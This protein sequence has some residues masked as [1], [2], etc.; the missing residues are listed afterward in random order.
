[1]YQEY[2]QFQEKPFSLTPDPKFLYP[3]VKHQE[4]LDH[5]LY[6]IRQRE[7]F[8]LM[9]G[10]VGTG[11][12]T[13]CRSLLEKLDADVKTALVL[14]PLGSEM[15]LLRTCLADLGV[16]RVRANRLTPALAGAVEQ[17]P[18][19]ETTP[20]FDEED[21]EGWTGHASKK[22]L[23]DALNEYLLEQHRAGGTVVLI[24]DEAQNLSLPVLEQL[25][26]LSNL[27]TEK[28]KLL[29]I[30]FAGQLE[31]ADK[32]NLPELK[33]L[34]ERIS[35]RCRIAPLS[36]EETQQY[37]MHRVLVAGAGS[38][39]AFAPSGLNAIHDYSKGV[40][41]RIN[42]VCDRALLA[43]FNAQAGVLERSHVKQAIRSLAGDEG[44]PVM[45]DF[46][47]LRMPLVL[48]I[49]FIIAGLALFVLPQKF[50][51]KEW[52]ITN[53]AGPENVEKAPPA[54]A[55][56][57]QDPP[58]AVKTAA[59][60][61]ETNG[62]AGKQDAI[63]YR[64]QVSTMSEAERAEK[65]VDKLREEGYPAYWKKAFSSKRDWYI[66]YVGPYDRNPPARIHLNAL[67]YS[68]RHPILLSF[69]SSD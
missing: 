5:L 48:G 54:E 28:D 10:D 35:I 53:L 61:N 69:T 37:I 25:R 17:H 65:E 9:V 55:P 63:H 18:S 6:G 45:R 40:P 30:I 49:L 67:K 44:A 22:E 32:L 42:L 36:R 20:Y 15:D 60:A 7:G 1:M 2:Y 12:T 50:A 4:A 11:K 38:R 19:F 16:P 13:L 64:I 51:Q 58:L 47:W 21:D 43:G 66:V 23:T 39:L 59:S 52:R 31:L 41:R 29:Q 27:E 14:D 68:G 26:L 33:Q 3:S 8:M 56:P 24:I 62:T 46:L 34:N 57:E